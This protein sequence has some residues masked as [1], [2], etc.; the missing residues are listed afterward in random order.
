MPQGAA[1][2]KDHL[3][4]QDGRD[5]GHLDQDLLGQVQHQTDQDMGHPEVLHMVRLLAAT[6]LLDPIVEEVNQDVAAWAHI[7]LQK[8]I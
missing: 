3:V 1:I 6:G 2:H 4:V 8:N 7:S 5:L